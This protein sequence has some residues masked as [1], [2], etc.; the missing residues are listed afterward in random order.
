MI[1]PISSKKE[2]ILDATLRLVSKK[3]SFDLT[4]REIAKEA[5]VNV[6]AINYYFKSKEELYFEMERLFM[7]NFKDA[8]TP[9]DDTS[10]DNTQ[11][12]Y[13]WLKKA[14]AY[15]NHYPGILVFLKDKISNP[16]NSEFESNMIQ[17]L[18]FRLTQVKQLLLD[19]IKPKEQ[20][21]EHLF[22]AFSS[23]IVF[24]FVVNFSEI[25][26]PRNEKEHFEY[27]KLI[28]E[29]FKER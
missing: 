21:R 11:R 24:P 4:I 25:G 6:A 27:I 23:G 5:D 8:F 13:V 26:L 16:G 18:L 3:N 14:I 29:K 1:R 17:G 22:M 19:V 15:A 9:L 7:E 28:I 10:L 20:E 12:L 2:L